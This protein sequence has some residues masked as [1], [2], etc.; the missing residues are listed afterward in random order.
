MRVFFNSTFYTLYDNFFVKHTV[1]STNIHF[2]CS[3][4][5][6]KQKFL[7]TWH[8]YLC[9]IL[10]ACFNLRSVFFHPVN[11]DVTNDRKGSL[12]RGT[13]LNFR[14]TAITQLHHAYCT[15]FWHERKN[16]LVWS[17]FLKKFSLRIELYNSVENIFLAN[18]ILISGSLKV[19]LF[20]GESFPN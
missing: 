3:L 11:Y 16:N 4:F 12:A 8:K 5:V 9:T 6:L 7:W 20:L 1:F 14:F 13:N 2:T 15:V 19:E 18:K 10:L 17:K